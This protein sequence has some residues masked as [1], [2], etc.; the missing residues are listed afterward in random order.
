MVSSV[1]M[2]GGEW[3]EASSGT[4]I[5]TAIFPRVG[6]IIG[7]LIDDRGGG[8][9][10]SSVSRKVTALFCKNGNKKRLCRSEYNL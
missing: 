7:E 10:A 8:I 5:G 1:A 6:T 9:G 3:A 2:I 4:S